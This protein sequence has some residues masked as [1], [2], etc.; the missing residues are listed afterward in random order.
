MPTTLVHAKPLSSTWLRF[1]RLL[2]RWWVLQ[3]AASQDRFVTL[4]PLVSVMLFLAAIISAFWY[5]RNEEVERETESLKRDTEIVQQQL[6]LH[7]IENQEQLV[8][9]ASELMKRETDIDDFVGQAQAFVRERPAVTQFVWI[10]ANRKRKAGRWATLYREDRAPGEADDPSLPDSA[11]QNPP[12]VA[13]AQSRELRQPVYS[14]TFI[15]AMGVPVIQVHVPLV[16]R[17][18]FAGS[19]MVEYSVEALLRHFVPPDIATRHSMS[20][21]DDRQQ[22]L[23]GTVTPMP[24]QPAVHSAPIVYE[25]PLAPAI[26]GLLLRG[27]GYRTSIGL[28]SNTLFWMVVALSVLTVWMLLGSWRHLRRRAQ[29]QSALVQET[30]F[31]RAMENSMLTGMRAMDLDGRITYVNAA[32]CAMTGFSEA[33]RA[34][35]ALPLLAAGP[36]RRDGP[37]AAAG[38]QRPQPGRRHRGAGDAQGRLAVRRAHVRLA[39]D[40]PA[41]PA[42]RLDDLD[43]Q[44]HR[45]QAHP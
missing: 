8:R 29:I 38:A 31:R 25:L 26:N 15:D 7:L 44:H 34:A 11:L 33:A 32:F 36:C 41:R 6:R 19:L 42:D 30:N 10:D 22:I 43:D 35:A 24:G 21:V 17:N 14:G 2:G 5:L 40:R 16:A 3:P 28:I 37:A 9:M 20:V 23:A 18:T 27:Q 12:G 4:A 39:A 13:F 1:R 45:G